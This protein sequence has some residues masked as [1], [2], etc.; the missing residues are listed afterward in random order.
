MLFSNGSGD[1]YFARTIPHRSAIIHDGVCRFD[2]FRQAKHAA[3][4]AFT[5]DQRSGNTRGTSPRL[6][7]PVNALYSYL[8]SAV[9]FEGNCDSGLVVVVTGDGIG[10]FQLSA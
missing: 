9:S 10:G 6:H 7:K 2:V 1:G 5:A 8:V 3:V 4:A